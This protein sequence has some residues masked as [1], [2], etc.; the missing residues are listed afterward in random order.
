MKL[1]QRVMIG[2]VA[3]FV[4]VLALLLLIGQYTLDFRNLFR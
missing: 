1:G 4:I 3:G 2:V